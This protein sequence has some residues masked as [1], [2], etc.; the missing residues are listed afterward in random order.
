MDARKWTKKDLFDT[1]FQQRQQQYY[2]WKSVVSYLLRT[3]R[4]IGN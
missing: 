3:L 1:Y 2:S 4:L